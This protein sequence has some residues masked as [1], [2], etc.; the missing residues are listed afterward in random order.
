M[1][2]S[3]FSKYLVAFISIILI[4]FLMI[5]A[6]ITSMIR[7][8]VTDEKENQLYK[9]TSSIAEAFETMAE[10]DRNTNTLSRIV[11]PLLNRDEALE[12]MFADQN[13]VIILSSI[14]ATPD[15]ENGIRYPEV[16][17]ALGKIDIS[18]F[19]SLDDEKYGKYFLHR[20]TLDSFLEESSVV[21]AKEVPLKDGAHGY[22]IALYSTAKDD[23]LISTTR[24]TVINSSAWVMLAAVIAVYFITDRIIRPLKNMTSAAKS[25]G[26]G[27][28]STRV[29]VYGSDE[30]AA[31]G[32]AF[33][34]MADSLQNLEKMRSSFLASVSHD[35]RTPMTTIAG[36]IDGIMS[37][38]I[39]A[40]KQEYYLQIIS[41]EIHRLSRLVSQIL[42]ISRLESGDR[43]MNF[44]TF[45]VAEVARIVLLSFEKK[46][47]EKRLDVNFYADNENEMLVCADKDA[48]H[49]VIYNLCHNAIKFSREEGRLEI[50]I[51]EYGPKQIKISVYDDGQTI[52]E[53][54]SHKIFE[55]FYKTDESRGLDKTGVGLGLYISKTIIDSHGE[56][57]GVNSSEGGEGCEFFFTLK[58]PNAKGVKS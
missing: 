38:A 1:F 56:T 7:S 26:D 52:S 39:P 18:L 24:R 37:G 47:D 23:A 36:F 14:K 28:F 5:S 21:C 57:I 50:N 42:D 8:Y 20:G 9:T 49:Q 32:N 33:N 41:S 34:N 54:E 6:I 30:V 3:M 45:D 29:A 17:A 58:K 48:I 16:S 15:K 4:S 31:L 22:I 55:R 40:D 10:S 11:T 51:S 12:V 53:E 27:D 13:G 46:I 43:K 2:K 35:L 25:F 44:E 19:N